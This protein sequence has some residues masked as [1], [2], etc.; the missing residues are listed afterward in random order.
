MVG[1]LPL[2][3]LLVGLLLFFGA[4]LRLPWPRL[5]PFGFGNGLRVWTSCLPLTGLQMSLASPVSRLHVAPRD[6][7]LRR[8]AAC[9]P[10]SAH[11][12]NLAVCL[13]WALLLCRVCLL[14]VFSSGAVSVIFLSCSPFWLPVRPE[15]LLEIILGRLLCFPSPRCAFVSADRICWCT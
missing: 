15:A 9:V 6:H 14:F 1:G 8:S 7:S 11:S 4:L 5:S 13:S 3:P 12:A 2:P 10:S